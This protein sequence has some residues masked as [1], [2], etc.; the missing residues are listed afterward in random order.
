MRNRDYQSCR[1]GFRHCDGI[2]RRRYFVQAGALGVGG[3]LLPDLLLRPRL[4]PA[5]TLDPQSARFP[6]FRKIRI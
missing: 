4:P 6:Q 2:T 1:A 3:L 5:A